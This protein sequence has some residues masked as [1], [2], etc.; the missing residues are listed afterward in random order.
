MA[1][2]GNGPIPF[3]ANQ[4]SGRERFGTSAGSQRSWLASRPGGCPVAWFRWRPRA[5]R[6]KN[7]ELL[8]DYPVLT[9]VLKRIVRRLMVSLYT[10]L[11]V[12]GVPRWPQQGPGG[13]ETET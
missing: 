1:R 5:H 8:G 13:K 7:P 10:A 12:L 4:P 9:N 2:G 6:S 3:P 11:E